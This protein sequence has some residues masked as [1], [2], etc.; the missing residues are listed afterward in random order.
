[1]CSGKG[2]VRPLSLEQKLS[3][4]KVQQLSD[5]ASIELG[6]QGEKPTLIVLGPLWRSS[7]PRFIEQA[8]TWCRANDAE[9]IVLSTDWTLDQ[10]RERTA[11][12][13]GELKVYYAEWGGW[14]L[15]K[16]WEYSPLIA[17]AILIDAEGRAVANPEPLTLPE[18]VLQ[19]PITLAIPFESPGMVISA[20]HPLGDGVDPD[21]W[22][23]GYK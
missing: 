9:L 5:G 23:V 10:T 18:K 13:S 2:S 15:A 19:S 20:L 21:K 6:L 17:R 22:S 14:Q 16:N 3:P 4:I 7:T 1:M 12:Y 11:E 8:A